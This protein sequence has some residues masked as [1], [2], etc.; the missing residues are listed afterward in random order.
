MRFIDNLKLKLHGPACVS[1][2]VKAEKYLIGRAQIEGFTEEMSFLKQ[3]K[4]V[5]KDKPVKSNSQL[6][7]L[8]PF[9][10][11][12][13]LLRVGGRIQQGSFPT[14]ISHPAILPKGHFVSEL[15]LKHCHELCGH[16]GRGMT[17][18]FVRSSGFWIVGLTSLASSVIHKCVTC[19]KLRGG[20]QVQQMCELPKDRL[21]AGPPF[22]HIGVDYFGPFFIKDGRREVKR[23]GVMF[24]CLVSRGVHIEAAS[25]LDTDA[26]INALR[27]FM[28]I[29]GPI[30]TLRCDRGTN[31]V[32]GI[33]QLKAALDNINDDQVR[34]FLL[35]QSCDYIT[36]FPHSSH[37]GGVW[38]RQIRTLRSVF[39]SL[40][41]AHGSQLDD[42]CLRTLFYEAA[43]IINSRPLTVDTLNDPNSLLPIS[44]NNLLTMKSNVVLPPP[45]EFQ[46]A[47]GY[48][49]KRWRR[50]EFLAQMQPRQKWVKKVRN[51]QVGDIVL[52]TDDDLPRCQWKLGRIHEVFPDCDGLIRKVKIL[53]G[54]PCLGKTFS[55]RK[56][57]E[58]PIHKVVLLLENS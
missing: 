42:D 39:S 16:Q 49:R 36:N 1:D 37:Q 4:N 30:R 57:L 33:K 13:G 29:R 55:D 24:T 6:R 22:T 51:L 21:E 43:N 23:Y 15:I 58:R 25:T 32:G 46:S 18:Q 9:L 27:R 3:E 20:Q 7:K 28:S 26:F 14:E 38:E 48:S 41:V 50:V 52:I 54:D 34:E 10:D 5:S 47:D 2:L 45:G 56:F 53:V 31:L 40:L 44:P 19:R 17:V 8:N 12:D 35:N 11:S